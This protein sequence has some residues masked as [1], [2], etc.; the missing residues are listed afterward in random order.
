MSYINKKVSLY[1]TAYEFLEQI[2]Q[3]FENNTVIPFT[4]TRTNLPYNESV[5]DIP[6][7]TCDWDNVRI[8]IN[9]NGNSTN[10]ASYFTLTMM[11][12]NLNTNKYENIFSSTYVLYYQD[13]LSNNNK[14]S[15]K[16]VRFIFCK[17]NEA[18]NII[19]RNYNESF[20]AGIFSDITTSES[21][22]RLFGYYYLGSYNQIKIQDSSFDSYYRISYYNPPIE[23]SQIILKYQA[24][25]NYYYDNSNTK[26][27]TT[28]KNMSSISFGS[29]SDVTGT[30]YNLTTK[31]GKKTYLINNTITNSSS[32]LYYG[33]GLETGS[34]VT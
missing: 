30:L 14:A 23:A 15:A 2:A 7:V 25:V 21:P 1:G 16:K 3:T 19:I 11:Q 20:C 22:I 34:E 29:T 28:L 32:N 4:V 10:S 17:N 5:T 12:K 6:S 8:V 13:T 26:Y 27:L 31:S 33:L 9:M 24:I 18:V